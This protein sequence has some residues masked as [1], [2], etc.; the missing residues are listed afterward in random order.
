MNNDEIIR[1]LRSA[2][3]KVILYVSGLFIFLV[4]VDTYLANT[5]EIVRESMLSNSPFS[6]I[7]FVCLQ[8]AI[9]LIFTYLEKILIAINQT[10]QSY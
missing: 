5:S 6:M 10:N 8:F 2:K 1:K 3:I 7:I 9:M 4:W